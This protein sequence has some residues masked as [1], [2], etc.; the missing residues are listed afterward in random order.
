LPALGHLRINDGS[1]TLQGIRGNYWV[2]AQFD[3]TNGYSPL[4]ESNVSNPI[5]Y[6]S[7]AHGLS[8]RCVR[9]KPDFFLPAV[10]FRSVDGVL[11]NQR[12]YGY[13]WSSTDDNG[14]F[15]DYLRFASDFNHPSGTG[16]WKA[17][18]VTIRCVRQKSEKN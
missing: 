3:S 15:G 7:K 14:I 4:F 1:L 8:V 17:T 5:N 2:S 18:G 11:A 10:G 13:Y 9:W 6:A 12:T 16:G